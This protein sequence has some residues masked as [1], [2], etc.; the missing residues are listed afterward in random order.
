MSCPDSA[1]N[2]S[3]FTSGMFAP[4]QIGDLARS[5]FAARAG[6]MSSSSWLEAAACGLVCLAATS[7]SVCSTM[8]AT[9]RARHRPR[10]AGVRP[11]RVL[12]SFNASTMRARRSAVSLALSCAARPV[13]SV[14]PLAALLRSTR[15]CGDLMPRVRFSS[16]SSVRSRSSSSIE[17]GMFRCG[18]P[19]RCQSAIGRQA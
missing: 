4:G 14:T 3:R 13:G 16:R 2:R 5:G 6:T 7:C 19:G 18:L 1:A 8:A 17:I 12:R 10:L 11:A 9:A 15:F